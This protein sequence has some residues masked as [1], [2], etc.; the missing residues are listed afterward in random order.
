MCRLKVKLI[1]HFFSLYD[2]IYLGDKMTPIYVKT[3]YSFLSSLITIDELISFAKK[4]NYHEL[5]ICDDNMYGV[6]EFIK[7]CNLNN[8]KPIVGLEV[9]NILLFA[10]NYK[11]YINLIKLEKIKNEEE[12]TLDILS[13]YSSDLISFINNED[14]RYEELIKIYNDYYIFS[15]DINNKEY[16]YL[17]KTLCLNKEDIEILKYV[18]LLRDNKIVSDEYEFNNDICFI[19]YN[20]SRYQEFYNK[21]NLL[22]PK[23]SINLPDFCKYNNT[24]GMNSDDYLYNLSITGLNK[25][26]NNIITLKYKNRLLYEL[27]VIKKMGFSNYFL[28]VYDYIK[29]AKT[30]DILTGPG[31]GSAAGSLV[32]YS[33]GITDIDPIKYDL[34]FERFLNSERITMPDIDT[35]FPYDKREE[36][37]NYCINKYGKEKVGL[38]TTFSA[39]GSKMALRDMG[40]VLNIPLYVIDDLIKKIGN[41]SLN[42]S[43]NNEKIKNIINSDIKL[44]KLYAIAKR[45]EGLPRHSSIHAA[46]III[47]DNDLSNIVPLNFNGDKYIIEYEKDYLEELGLIKMD[48]LGL[49]NLTIIDDTL[50]L[51]KEYEKIDIK[52]NEIP[53]NDVN[54]YKLFSKGDTEGIFQFESLGMINFLKRLKPTCFEDIYNANAFFRPGPSN[55]IDTFIRRR[56]NLDAVDYF[57]KRLENIL[58]STKGII[59]YQEQIMEILKIVG[60]FSLGEADILRRAIS[61]KKLEDIKKYKDKFIEG[62]INNGYTKELSDKIYNLILEF[63]S[64]GFNKSHSVAYSLISY[65]MAYL[66]CHYPLYFY[67]SVLNSVNLDIEK[68]IMYIKEC[69]RRNIKITKPD[70]NKS[71]DIYKVYYNSIILPL[72]IIKGLSN[73]VTKKIMEIRKNS[74]TSIYDFFI[75]MTKENIN[76][77][78]ITSLIKSGSLDSLKFNRNTLLYNIDNLINYGKLVND[79]EDNN[80]LKPEIVFME[81]LSRD[82][83]INDEKEIFGFYLS[84]HPTNIYKN[85][86]KNIINLVDINKYFNKYIECIIMIDSIKVITTKTNQEMAFIKGSDEEEMV[87]VIVFPKVYNNLSNIKKGDIIKVDGKVEKKA[88]YQ[89]IANAIINVKENI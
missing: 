14:K 25:R 5:C 43:I 24:H 88:S 39:F 81:E 76:K 18:N 31:R 63:A 8:I 38:I 1:F 68:T 53:L 13:K 21:C 79:L 71:I 50:K 17:H 37:I 11:G 34:L 35:D 26:L 40:R 70:I 23:Y 61:K 67:V 15:T 19:N 22:L 55:N 57:D 36:V 41:I 86:Y 7:K 33:L 20:D 30:N 56:L 28:I 9:S 85:K 2:K 74:F 83:L 58:K 52:F 3:V 75:K 46:G 80:L 42:D 48:F 87:E 54:T 66:K 82:E 64:Y 29:Y 51:I 45:I 60:G 47:S 84:N 77:N 59:V 69:K 44:K 89:I 78:I 32:S 72:N 49:K 27:D 4:N 65:K 6:M 62:A 73:V 16:L 10:K 12:I